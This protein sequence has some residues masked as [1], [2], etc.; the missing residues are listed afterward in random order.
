MKTQSKAYQFSAAD[1]ADL[2]SLRT[3][4][5]ARNAA[6]EDAQSNP[7]AKTFLE[8]A[9]EFKAGIS[10]KVAALHLA[11]DPHGAY[12]HHTRKLADSNSPDMPLL[13]AELE[14]VRQDSHLKKSFQNLV[15]TGNAYI[16]S[17]QPVEVMAGANWRLSMLAARP[18]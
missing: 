7:L 16:N 5:N 10:T 6:R 8:A 11:G 3:V 1:A 17:T 12:Y 18:F 13:M 4:Y 9:Q 14:L 2:T 15:A